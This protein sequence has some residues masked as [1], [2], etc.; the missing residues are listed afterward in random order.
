MSC[1][2]RLINVHGFHTELEV[3]LCGSAA[4]DTACTFEISLEL[5]PKDHARLIL[6]PYELRQKLPLGRAGGAGILHMQTV[7]EIELE[8]PLMSYETRNGSLTKRGGLKPTSAVY[9][10]L[11]PVATTEKQCA[12]SATVAIPLHMRYL[13]AS[14]T[15]SIANEITVPLPRVQWMCTRPLAEPDT[16]MTGSSTHKVRDIQCIGDQ[17]SVAV[18]LGDMTDLAF[19]RS[20]QTIVI[21]FA[22]LL[23]IVHTWQTSRRLAYNRQKTV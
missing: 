3:A 14:S 20:T 1:S 19:I 7:G 4:A 12:S 13:P 8:A 21:F 10:K 17:M 6:D 22:T 18:P 2:G 9:I 5:R 23:L 11:G 16:S 15:G